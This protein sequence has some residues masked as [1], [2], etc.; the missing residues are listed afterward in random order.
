MNDTT[1]AHK[2]KQGVMQ[3]LQDVVIGA[4]REGLTVA[5]ASQVAQAEKN[6]NIGLRQLPYESTVLELT[7]ILDILEQ[8]YLEACAERDKPDAFEVTPLVRGP[9][10]K[11]TP[12][13]KPSA[14]RLK[15]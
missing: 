4:W 1:I 15:K 8:H 12:A 9:L 11:A 2:E 3:D 13:K 7:R 14:R 6:F 5:F 10:P